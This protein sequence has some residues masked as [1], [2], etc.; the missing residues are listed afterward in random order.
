MFDPVLAQ[1]L[2]TMLTY[3]ACGS[4]AAALVRILNRAQPGPR[5]DQSAGIGFLVG[6]AFGAF[7]GIF[8]S[9]MARS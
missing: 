3:G 5:V 9:M 8:Q 4:L 1:V 2:S 6:A 7:L